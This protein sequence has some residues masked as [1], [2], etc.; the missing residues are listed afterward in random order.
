[1]KFDLQPKQSAKNIKGMKNS[2]KTCER[3]EIKKDSI[4]VKKDKKA[5]DFFK[6]LLGAFFGTVVGWLFGAF[7][8]IL[9]EVFVGSGVGGLDLG[10]SDALQ[11]TLANSYVAIVVQVIFVILGALIG[12]LG[13]GF[14]D[15]M[16]RFERERELERLR[17][18][19][20]SSPAPAIERRSCDHS[21]TVIADNGRT[22]CLNCGHYVDKLN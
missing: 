2:L 20:H 10:R 4:M 12:F 5:F 3:G 1:L 9:F 8:V 21:Q 22:F 19:R 13:K 6:G 14:E 16:I 15:E 17:Y 11:E 18:T 7:L